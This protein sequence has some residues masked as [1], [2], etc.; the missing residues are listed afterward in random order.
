MK[1][2]IIGAAGF[3]GGYLASE[4][5]ARGYAVYVTKLRGEQYNGAAER[6]YDADITVPD[7]IFGV[8]NEVAPDAVFHLAAQSSVRL[9]WERPAL[10]VDVNIKGTLEVL[11]ACR[12]MKDAGTE[13]RIL[14][15]GSAEEYGKVRP[16]DCPIKEET[17]CAPANVY[18]LTKLTQNHLGR[19]YKDAYGLDIVSVRSFN[20]TGPGQ[21]P[22]FVLPD[23][24]FQVSEIEKGRREPTISVGNLEAMRD[25]TDVRDIVRA[26]SVLAEKGRA[27]ETYNV[28]S[29]KA[30]RIADIL[31]TVLNEARVPIKVVSDPARMRPS[32]VPV[33]VA[34]I[35][36]LKRETGW[37][38]R[39]G[40]ARTVQDTLDLYRGGAG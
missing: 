39:I 18:A 19:M 3:V 28:G 32:D 22:S 7:E 20:H 8:M 33:Q 11:E 9:S 26:Y 10:T 37:E 12:K 38:P 2:L 40:L 16:Q 14:L 6:V 27:G 25:F 21:S 35:T 23:F 13:A 34:D 1:A 24:C 31:S 17:P 36:K 4:L 5:S 30:V 29:G 15:V